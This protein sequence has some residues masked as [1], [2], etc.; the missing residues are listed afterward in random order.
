MEAQTNIIQPEIMPVSITIADIEEVCELFRK[1]PLPKEDD[2]I[3]DFS[4]IETIT[5]P[6]IQLIIALQK[7]MESVGKSI[8]IINED[9]GVTLAFED[10]GLGYL[11]EKSIE[12]YTQDESK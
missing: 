8:K 5:T 11:L 3:L 12:V 7:K 4:K 9:S 10:I 6:G 2:L 1:I